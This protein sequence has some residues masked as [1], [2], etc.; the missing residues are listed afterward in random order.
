MTD[1]ASLPDIPKMTREEMIEEL[2]GYQRTAIES[3][4]DHDLQHQMVRSRTQAYSLALMQQVHIDGNGEGHI[5]GFIQ[6]EP[7]DGQYL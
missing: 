4:A 6:E 2:V 7:Q 3:M 5:T 1:F